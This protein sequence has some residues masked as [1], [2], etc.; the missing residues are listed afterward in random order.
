[1]Q[2]A[3]VLAWDITMLCK[4]YLD[5][6]LPTLLAYDYYAFYHYSHPSPFQLVF[7]PVSLDYE[8]GFPL[9]CIFCLIFGH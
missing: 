8:L 7:I 3:K 9:N 4:N 1:M 6:I 2:S 5:I